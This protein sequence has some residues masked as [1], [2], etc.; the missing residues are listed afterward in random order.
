MKFTIEDL[1]NAFNAAKEGR[2]EKIPVITDQYGSV[3]I[4]E[5]FIPN[6]Y[7]TFDDWY[8]TYSKTEEKNHLVNIFDKKIDEWHNSNTSIPLCEYLGITK[9]QYEVWV[10]EKNEKKH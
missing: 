4:E 7:P 10:T 5:H 8:N 9:E 1:R 2:V 3:N 6:K